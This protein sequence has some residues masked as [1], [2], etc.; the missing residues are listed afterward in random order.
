MQSKQTR[1]E[2]IGLVPVTRIVTI[3]DQVNLGD[4][5]NAE[6]TIL[7]LQKRLLEYNQY[8]PLK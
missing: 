4:K 1:T 2:N 6:Q 3:F 8:A 7:E 5:G